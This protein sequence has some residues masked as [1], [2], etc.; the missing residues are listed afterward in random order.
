MNKN[1]NLYPKKIREDNVTKAEEIEKDWNINYQDKCNYWMNLK[2][3]GFL[4]L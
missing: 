2:N 4:I 1:M 3:K